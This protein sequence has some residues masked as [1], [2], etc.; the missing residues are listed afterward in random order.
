M[1]IMD[2]D[3][4][5]KAAAEPEDDDSAEFDGGDGEQ[6]GLPWCRRGELFKASAPGQS[7]ASAGDVVQGALGDCWFLGALS[8]LATN[9]LQLT[10][11]FWPESNPEQFRD[12]VSRGSRIDPPTPLSHATASTPPA[13]SPTT[14]STKCHTTNLKMSS[15]GQIAP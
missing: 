10:K 3:G 15:D 9:E 2:V 6:R 7:A 14:E 11:V 12:Q 13:K 1:Q 8:V 4:Q 5:P